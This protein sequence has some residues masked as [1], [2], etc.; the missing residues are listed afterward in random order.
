MFD[1][2]SRTLEI[3]ALG[4]VTFTAWRGSDITARFE[5]VCVAG[6]LYLRPSGGELILR[7]ERQEVR[8][9]D[10]REPTFDQRER[11]AEQVLA[12]LVRGGAAS[13]LASSGLLT[14][15]RR[16]DLLAARSEH[17]AQLEDL[18]RRLGEA[19]ANFERVDAALAELGD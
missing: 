11:V 4:A 19:R 17:L 6:F 8:R 5:A 10:G 2:P 7:A 1:R 13:F 9:V 14:E 12:E 15:S 3:P 16:A 18:E